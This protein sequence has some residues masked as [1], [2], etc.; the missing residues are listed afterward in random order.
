MISINLL[1]EEFRVQEKTTTKIPVFK[2]AIAVGGLFSV[3][4]LFFYIDFWSKHIQLSKLNKEWRTVEPQSQQLKKLEQD[5]ENNL[6]PENIFLK[7]F[8]TSVQPLTSILGWLNEYLPAATWL[9]Q[10]QMDRDGD[11]GKLVVKGLTLPTKE[12]SSI[13]T[14]EIYL[15]ALKAKMP[16]ANLSLTTSRQQIKDTEVTQF[17]ATFD[18]APTAM[19]VKK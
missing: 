4:T 6:K 3:L 2:I 11:G 13:E 7:R 14:I 19:V 9:T 18:W 1:P 8:A 10:V 16:E 15:N 12:K 5:V 17:V